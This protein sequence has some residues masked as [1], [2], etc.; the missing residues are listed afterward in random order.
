MSLIINF[1][2]DALESVDGVYKGSGLCLLEL[3]NIYQYL[4]GF[5]IYTNRKRVTY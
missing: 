4:K 5:A 3:N 2:C 1:S